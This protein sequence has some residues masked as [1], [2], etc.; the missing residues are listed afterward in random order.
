MTQLP[1][2]RVGADVV[3]VLAAD[4]VVVL[5]ANGTS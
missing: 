2:A 1:C 3:A 5:A 4:V